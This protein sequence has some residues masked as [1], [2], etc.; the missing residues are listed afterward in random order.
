MARPG[1]LGRIDIGKSD[2]KKLGSITN[3]RPN[4]Y[5]KFQIFPFSPVKRY[6]ST[7]LIDLRLQSTLKTFCEACSMNVLSNSGYQYRLADRSLLHLGS[8]TR[9]SIPQGGAE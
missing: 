7:M 6:E 3:P 5:D 4:F 8:L 2:K 9:I 1:V